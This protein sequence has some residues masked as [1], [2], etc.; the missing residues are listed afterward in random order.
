MASQKAKNLTQSVVF[1]LVI[2]GFVAV[3]NYLG[4]RTFFRA[5]LTEN[6]AYSI[7][8]ASKRILKN[9]DDIVNIKVY[10]SKN[11]PPKFQQ[12]V[13]DVRDLLSEYQAYAG[14][15]LRLEWVDP[16]ESEETKQKVRSL[17]IPEVQM[18]TFEKDK[19]QVINGYLGIAVLYADKKEVLPLVQ[20]LR[21]FEYDLTLAIMKV[22][23]TETPKI[24]VLKTDTVPFIP[25]NLRRQM[26]ITDQTEE[27]YQPIFKHLKTNYDVETVDI[28]DGQQ[29]SSDIKTLIVPGGEKFTERKI[30]EIDQYFMNGGN[31]IVLADAV[32]VDFQY[33]ITGKTQET[34]LLDLLEHYGARVEKNMVLDAS[35]G[36]VQIPQQFGQFQMNVAVNYPYFVLI[37]QDGFNSDNPA[38]APL[39][40]VIMPWTSSITLLVDKKNAFAG[41]DSAS[42]ETGQDASS[43]QA[44]TATVLAQSSEKSWTA[45]GNFNLD[46]KQKWDPDP[47]SFD[48]HNL[49]VHLTG[50]FTSYFK[51]A[52]VPPVKNNDESDTLAQIQ[53]DDKDKN[54]EVVK[55]NTD[56]HLVIAGDSDFLTQQNA[57][58]NNVTS[59]LNLV[60]WLTLDK[61][62]IEIRT[63]AVTD[64]TISRDRLG[65]GSLKPNIIRYV[66][67]VLMPVILIAVGLVIFFRRREKAAPSA[68]S[69]D[70]AQ[71]TTDKPTE[72]QKNEG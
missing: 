54:R 10:F 57:T 35:C 18:Q 61:N 36:Q 1:V 21:N 37:G 4:T 15:K 69:P 67:I 25:V 60:D 68:V 70:K 28:S 7:S 24:G 12:I 14:N 6:R 55:S 13:T 53:L 63:R 11:L 56:R 42:T 26:N 9:L 72:E 50:D 30:F 45:T 19:A 47:E 44:V 8:D 58:P 39:A 3:V 22:M 59:L 33:G 34:K 32:K 48:R 43:S 51:D 5:D 64:R 2:L 20:D 65:E 31:L 66:N 27:K 38:V 16:A 71:K 49:M 52:S 62:L 46:P 17:G 40:E 29:I 23:R 41:A